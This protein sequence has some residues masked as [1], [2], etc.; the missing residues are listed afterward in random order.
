MLA[1]RGAVGAVAALNTSENG[2][3]DAVGTA[4]AGGDAVDALA[5]A[6]YLVAA[7]A[8]EGEAA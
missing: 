4:A 7:L 5:D 6:L 1:H 2:Q 8:V 3:I